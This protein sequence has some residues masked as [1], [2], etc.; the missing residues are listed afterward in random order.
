M[1]ECT[2]DQFYQ[3]MALSLVKRK[4][5][6]AF[7]GESPSF[8][9]DLSTYLLRKG[10]TF[11]GIWH[12]NINYANDM[13]ELIRR[14]KDKIGKLITHIFPMEKA[15]EAFRLQLTGNCGKVILRP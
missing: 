10:L 6:I 14:S 2:G 1:I 11:H 13:I 7:I 12:W 15:E 4:G 5:Q 3:Q 8:T 9:F